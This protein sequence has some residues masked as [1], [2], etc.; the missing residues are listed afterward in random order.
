MPSVSS[1]PNDNNGLCS[2]VCGIV[3]MNVMKFRM[4]CGCV[5]EREIETDR[6]RGRYILLQSYVLFLLGMFNDLFAIN[7]A[8]L[9][10]VLVNEL[11]S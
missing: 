1:A 2:Y 8:C 4:N 6:Q 10:G 5:R 9:N 3:Q 7:S 11:T